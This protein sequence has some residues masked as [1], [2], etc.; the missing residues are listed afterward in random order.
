MIGKVLDDK[1]RLSRLIGEGGMG[2]VYEAEHQRIHR[3]VA[4]KL[5]R[6]EIEG[7]S[8]SVER[9]HREAMAAS[10]IGHPNIIEIFDVGLESDG[11]AFIVMELLR[12]VSL[13][14]L[15]KLE[16]VVVPARALSFALQIL[17]ALDAAHSKGIIHRDLK[18]DNVFLAVDRMLREVVKVLDFGVAKIQGTPERDLELTKS[19][20]V[21][22]SPFYLSP[23]QARGR[24]DLDQRVD[25]WAA[26]VILYQMLGGKRPFDGENYNEILGRILMEEP[27]PL[28]IL[29]PDIPPGLARVVERALAKDREQRYGTAREMLEAL[30][31]FHDP[32]PDE[33]NTQVIRVLGHRGDGAPGEVDPK[34][35]VLIPDVRLS[36]SPSHPPALRRSDPLSETMP[37]GPLP[38]LSGRSRSRMRRGILLGIAV[39]VLAVAGLVVGLVAVGG[40]EDQALG[41]E[42]G[43]SRAAIGEAP[44]DPT[45]APEGSGPDREAE[46][47]APANVVFSFP[48]LPADAAVTV[49]GRPEVPPLTLPRS[50]VPVI[51]RIAAPGHEPVDKAV[52]PNRDRE[53]RVPLLP[54]PPPEVRPEA[55]GKAP[56]HQAGKRTGKGKGKAPA[57]GAWADNPFQ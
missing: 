10:A 12:G 21:F 22:G 48:D 41:E 11:T 34:F 32:S 53:I 6:R 52:L 4:V 54:L 28:C 33:M 29:A 19:G 50:G 20:V 3:Q 2:T 37:S 5:M 18:P 51:L 49:D 8:A 23:E 39:L 30:L 45:A 7:S 42:A 24:R 17:S 43:S 38:D 56:L 15:L 44:D 9:F 36:S 16:G 31:E 40:H 26:G 27:I 57:D 25:L 1:Y 35:R 47:P 13:S 14:A 55:S 46:P